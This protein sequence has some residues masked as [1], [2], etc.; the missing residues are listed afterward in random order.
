MSEAV[1]VPS[2]MMMTL[3]VSEESLAMHRQTHTHRLGVDYVKMCK[4]AFDFANKRGGRGGAGG[5][6]RR[7]RRRRKKE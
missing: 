4:V 1:T 2:L 5:G 6:T 3:T 7:R